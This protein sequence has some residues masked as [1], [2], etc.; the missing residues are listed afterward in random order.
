MSSQNK[1]SGAALFGLAL[2]VCAGLLTVLTL[3]LSPAVG[4]ED[5]ATPNTAAS[6]AAAW[7]M[8]H[9]DS[10]RTGLSQFSTSGNVG[11]LR[12]KFGIGGD[13]DSSSAIGA[14]GTIYVGAASPENGQLYAINPNGSLKW[15]FATGDWVYSSPAIGADGTIYVGCD[16]WNVYALTDGGQGNVTMKWE[17][18]TG[19]DVDSSPAV[20]A[21]GTIYVV[22]GNGVLYAINP[23][24]SLKWWN[25][26]AVLQT[27][28]AIGAD[29]TIYVGSGD[30]NLYAI[31]PNGS[32]K[33]KFATWYGV[34]SSPAVGADGTIYVGSEFGTLYALT[35]K[36][37]LKWKFVTGGTDSSPAVGA[38]GSIYV[39]SWD[40]NLYAVG[41]TVM[42]APASLS[43]GTREVGK[44][45]AAK[46]LTLS[47][48]QGVKLTISGISA[49][50]D[51][52]VS[53]TTCGSS[54]GARESCTILVAFTPSTTG[55]RTGTLSVNDTGWNSPQTTS[56][57]GVGEFTAELSPKGLAFGTREV[58]ITSNPQ[59][60]TL[61][62][63]ANAEVTISGITASGDFAVSSTTCKS[64]LGP[65]AS[66]TVSVT[67]TPT[68]TGSRTGA[69]TV[70]DS[71]A[72]SPQIATLSGA[73]TWVVVSPTSLEFGKQ[74][75]KTTSAAK[76]VTLTNK[77]H[78]PIII[79][80][81]GASGDFAA[82]S[83][84]CGS[85][86]G[87]GQSCNVSVT[88]MPTTTGSRSG[89]L[90]VAA[91]NPFPT[92]PLLGTGIP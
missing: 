1:A 57:S 90:T 84:T 61:T 48:R 25:V 7:P 68:T 20:G 33:W 3:W 16:D 69:L 26:T 51:F 53:S 81:I 21:D 82:S 59:K 4:A 34:E 12:W 17:F 5:D 37:G 14:D 49:S 23:N 75:V 92:V 66:C 80:G 64:P 40:Y 32:L 76:K 11:A 38:D 74:T 89:T 85:S 8:F 28:P 19:G 65:L 41:P 6:P 42:L 67:F 72:N 91:S 77:G 31:N 15:K 39:G 63:Q 70:S 58:G 22:G 46:K 13:V 78:A 54:L 43:F 52:S 50:G 86:L 24:G 30:G 10:K 45:G 9:H 60:V 29:G 44:T 79:S 88:F 73:G 56:L 2:P 35:P 71:A 18:T 27:S 55:T 83:T 47:N 36:G 62:N 87:A